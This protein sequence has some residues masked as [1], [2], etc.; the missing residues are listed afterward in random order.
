MTEK[1]PISTKMQ[2]I[3]TAIELYKERGYENVSVKDICNRC[4]LTRGAFYY[5]FKSKDEIL[6]N[7][8]LSSDN[9]A[10]NEIL[11]LIS[12][13]KYIEQFYYF[14]DMYLERTF[15]A[16]HDIFGQIIKRNIDKS[17]KIFSPK[18]INMRKVYSSLIEKAQ[19]AGEILNRTP[20]D[21]L[22]DTIVYIADGIALVWCSQNGDFDY[23]E[24]NKKILDELFKINIA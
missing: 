9:L 22:V 19:N 21:L 13:K 23:V 16:G 20:P 8:F 5:H 14:F 24:E 18:D 7:Y 11:P 10:I 1:K 4:N 12:A 6:D 3:E 17:G 15:I 2:I